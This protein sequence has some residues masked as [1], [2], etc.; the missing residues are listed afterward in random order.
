MEVFRCT[1][2]RTEWKVCLPLE[3][4]V[5]QAVP[6]QRGPAAT[7]RAGLQS[8]DRPAL[9]RVARGDGRMVTCQPPAETDQN[10]C[11]RC[12]PCQ[13]HHLPA[14]RGRS[15]RPDGSCYHCR[16]SPIASAAVTR[17]TGANPKKNESG[18]TGPPDALKNLASRTARQR[19]EA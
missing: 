4:A 18:R 9:H 2:V 15:L 16:H 7:A 5:V 11:S 3:A 10:R 14:G 1:V 12:P 13:C 6:R 19:F 8:R 17:L